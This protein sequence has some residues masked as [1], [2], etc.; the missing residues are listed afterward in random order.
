L[1]FLF[2]AERRERNCPR[3]LSPEAVARF[4]EL[5]PVEAFP[6]IFVVKERFLFPPFQRISKLSSAA[7]EFRS[8]FP[9]RA[10]F[11]G[12]NGEG[13]D[14]DVDPLTKCSS[15]I[16][17]IK[18]R[19]G[20]EAAKSLRLEFQE[21]KMD[22]SDFLFKFAKADDPF[23]FTVYSTREYAFTDLLLLTK[24]KP[25][26]F[27][28][29]LEDGTTFEDCKERVEAEWG[30]ECS[31]LDEDGIEIELGRF[32]QDVQ[33][34]ITVERL[35]PEFVFPDGLRESHRIDPEWNIARVPNVDGCDHSECEF[36]DEGRTRIDE[37]TKLETFQ[38]KP[39]AVGFV[40]RF[41]C[42]VLHEDQEVA[43][44]P[45]V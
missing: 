23:D 33:G 35:F 6:L 5:V 37:A 30:H 24:G 45:N 15:V 41:K 10:H 13:F 28:L 32:V 43:F 21:E 39:I 31:F 8:K 25:K 20:F 18:A 36:F 22:D 9:I 26:T 3:H 40:Y 7:L 2:G 19:P 27:E 17:Q 16:R 38:G 11:R 34:P 44:L 1:A 29:D 12:L 4:S 42:V 14:L